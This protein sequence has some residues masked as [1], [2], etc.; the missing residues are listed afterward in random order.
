MAKNKVEFSDFEK[1][2]NKASCIVTVNDSGGA[3][4]DITIRPASD[5]RG[6]EVEWSDELSESEIAIVEKVTGKDWQ[7]A[8]LDAFYQWKNT[9]G[10]KPENIVIEK[11]IEE[12]P[13]VIPPQD[14]N[15]INIKQ[16]KG[17]ANRD[18]PK[19]TELKDLIKVQLEMCDP[20][21]TPI[22]CQMRTNEYANLEKQIITQIVEQGKTIGD[23]I[24]SIEKEFNPNIAD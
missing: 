15:D 21:D 18:S 24:I 7:D 20:I 19:L 17:R 5:R 6:D 16:A 12:N 4:A 8:V 2:G 9:R 10:K 11:D 14:F 3:T 22:I 23:A 13:I 1:D